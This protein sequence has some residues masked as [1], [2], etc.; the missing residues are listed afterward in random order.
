MAVPNTIEWMTKANLTDTPTR[1]SSRWFVLAGLCVM[2]AEGLAVWSLRRSGWDI[3]VS[4]VSWLG[5]LG[6]SIVPLGGACLLLLQSGRRFQLR[7]L[8]IAF[9][10]LA[11]FLSMTVRPILRYRRDRRTSFLLNAAGMKTDS[12]MIDYFLGVRQQRERGPT[13]EIGWLRPL[14]RDY[15]DLLRDDQIRVVQ[16]YNDDQCRLLASQAET[17]PELYHVA[18]AYGVFSK[19]GLDVLVRIPQVKGISLLG[20]DAMGLRKFKKAT[21]LRHL[22]LSNINAVVDFNAVLPGSLETLFIRNEPGNELWMNKQ[23]IEALS[24]MRS[25]KA[26]YLSGFNLIDDDLAPLKASTHLQHLAVWQSLVSKE[27]ERE[28]QLALPNCQVHC[29]HY[30]T[31]AEWMDGNFVGQ[32]PSVWIDNLFGEI[33][34]RVTQLVAN[35]NPNLRSKNTTLIWRNPA[36]LSVID[37]LETDDG[38]SKEDGDF[39]RTVFAESREDFGLPTENEKLVQMIEAD[40]SS[41]YE[42]L[43]RIL[44]TLEQKLDPDFDPWAVEEY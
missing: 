39:L 21:H 36:L 2:V 7:T 42:R 25:L 15:A 20:I 44:F 11:V 31:T 5:A 6:L 17:L 18:R 27:M 9:L 35:R 14:V 16:V 28:L 40:S 29:G 26:I 8:L 33:G 3:T 24:Q 19:D 23:H 38:L 12:Y 34:A 32:P 37:E 30:R 1:A 43:Q 10:L 22:M 41:S 13:S 4:S